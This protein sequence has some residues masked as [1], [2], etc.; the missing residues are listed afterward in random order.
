MDMG[1]G[2]ETIANK[3]DDGS[4]LRDAINGDLDAIEMLGILNLK[5][6]S[7]QACEFGVLS[8]LRRSTP[9]IASS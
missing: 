3:M 9:A 8:D 1:N 5:I 6:K 7:E 4:L 2:F